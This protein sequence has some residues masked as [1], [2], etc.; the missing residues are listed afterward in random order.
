[1]KQKRLARLET[2][3]GPACVDNFLLTS[4]NDVFYYTGFRPSGPAFFILKPRPT[5]Y[6]MDLDNEAEKVESVVFIKKLKELRTVL[7]RYRKVGYDEF[8]MDAYTLK[9]L[10]GVRLRPCAKF[11][12][13]PRMVKEPGEIEK[14]KTACNITKSVFKNLKI[15]GK[16]EARVARDINLAF[17]K[18]GSEQAFEP[19]VA[20]GPNGYYIHHIPTGKRI[21][22]DYMT[23]VD[24]GA[25]FGGYCSDMSRTFC[26]RPGRRGARVMD[27][28]EKIQSEIIDKIRPG[29][30]FESLQKVYEKLMKKNKYRI[31]HGVGHGVGLNVHEPLVG[32]LEPGTVLTIEPGV[33]IKKL[34]G[35]RIEDTVLV[36][37]SG[38][39]ILTG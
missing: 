29:V 10:R 39:K 20:T 26:E 34:G 23:V 14:I 36:R 16:T 11:I 8:G 13:Q 38:A 37:K 4:A 3:L 21:K 33:Y 1:M 5:L 28:V 19:V 22:P 6:V 15:F 35:C 30:K 25:K 2:L 32:E 18:N 9:A 7:K 12:K 27:D 17:I 31:W 24:A